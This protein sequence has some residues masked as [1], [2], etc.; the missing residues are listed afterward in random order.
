MVV[1]RGLAGLDVIESNALLLCAHCAKAWA[2]NSEPLSRRIDGGAPRTSTSSFKARMTGATGRLV[3]LSLRF[4]AHKCLDNPG[5]IQSDRINGVQTLPRRSG[6]KHT[7][8]PKSRTI[9]S[10]RYRSNLTWLPLAADLETV[11][12]R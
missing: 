4:E 5:A 9:R 6:L 8:R 7:S 10:D 12:P 11:C 1:L 3:K 2:M